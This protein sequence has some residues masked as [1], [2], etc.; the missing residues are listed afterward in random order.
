MKECHE[1]DP[2]FECDGCSK[3][4]SR[5]ENF[6]R[7][8]ESNNCI[9]RYECQFCHNDK[10]YFKSRKEAREHFLWDRRSSSTDKRPNTVYSCVTSV[11]EKQRRVE[12]YNEELFKKS[13]EKAMKW[14]RKWREMPE[15]WK[16]NQ[17]ELAREMYIEGNIK[18]NNIESWIRCDFL[19]ISFMKRK[20]GLKFLNFVPEEL[21][22]GEKVDTE[23]VKPSK[24]EDP[25]LPMGWFCTFC[26]PEPEF[27]TSH[28][29]TKHIEVVHPEIKSLN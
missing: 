8:D 24:P 23:R 20:Y 18:T 10:L 25:E 21:S 13:T 16:E 26:D 7:H 17:R 2:K 29:L 11:K 3:K 5:W 19:M 14:K 28:L 1:E 4:F 6:K 27:A 22:V 12:E 9:F 15:A